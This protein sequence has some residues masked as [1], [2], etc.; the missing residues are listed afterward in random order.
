MKLEKKITVTLNEDDIREAIAE[1]ASS[2]NAGDYLFT[3]DKVKIGR[4]EDGTL[5]ATITD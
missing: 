5:K 2:M 3:A 4:D 1:H